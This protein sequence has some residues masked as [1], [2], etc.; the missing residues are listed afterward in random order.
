MNYFMRLYIESSS[1][2]SPPS[3]E[4]EGAALSQYS[5]AG[6]SAN[7]VLQFLLL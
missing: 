5:A 4:I 6:Y 7:M 1:P 2:F 3:G